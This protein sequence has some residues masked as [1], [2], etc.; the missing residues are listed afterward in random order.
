MINT[1]IFDLGGV[2]IDNPNKGMFD[3][4]G[5]TL[6][7][8]YEK[9]FPSLVKFW[10]SWESG[11]ITES[12]LWQKI[13]TDLN[14]NLPADQPHW[15]N[16]YLPT[17]QERPEMFA[18]LA[19]LKSRGYQTALLSNIEDPIK[20]YIQSKKYRHVD[21]FI[22]SCELKMSKPDEAIYQHT[23]NV[24]QITPDQAVFVDDRKENIEAAELLGISG[25]LFED[26]QGLINQLTALQ[27][28]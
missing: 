16:A 6:G 1:I 13:G 2:L 25:I 23:L 15:L 7:L 24:L 8:P 27:V 19:T 10:K 4:F 9:L 14:I 18:L 3:Y 28:L 21:E 20:E 5:D 11:L 26:Y 22:F 17:Y 12:E